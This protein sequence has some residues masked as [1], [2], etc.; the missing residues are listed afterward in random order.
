M[1]GAEQIRAARAHLKWSQDMMAANT[2]LSATTIRNLESGDMSPRLSTM[3]IIRKVVEA[4][5][6]EFTDGNGIRQANL[7]G[8]MYQG[9]DSF[10]QLLNDMR[11]TVQENSSEILSVLSSNNLVKQLFGLKRGSLS[12]LETFGKRVVIKCL[13]PEPVDSS[14][15]SPR[16]QLRVFPKQHLGPSA[17]FVYGNKHVLATAEPNSMFRFNVFCNMSAAQDYRAHFLSL[18][19]VACQECAAEGPP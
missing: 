18:W 16:F 9:V 4:A 7:E 14:F 8:K 11:Q 17:Y 2:G 12:R 13:S 3:D 10:D 19:D 6:L 5:G 1:I 15:L